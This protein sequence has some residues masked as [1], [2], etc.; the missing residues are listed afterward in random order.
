MRTTVAIC[1]W[2]R[3]DLLDKTLERMQDLC[4]PEGLEWEL[5]VVNN[6]CTDHTDDVIER[7]REALPLR[8]LIE[9]RQGLSH[10]RNCAVEAARGDLLIWTDDDVLVDPQWLAE[11]VRA[12]GE[13]PDALFFG[14]TVTPWFGT[15]PPDWVPANLD[16]LRS[17]FAIADYGACERWLEANE[18]PVGANM[19]FRTDILRRH[20]FDGSL[21]HVG[22]DVRG[23][24][25]LDLIGQINR[26]G[27]R[28]VWLPDARV[29]HWIDPDRLTYRY[30]WKWHVG[31]GR[32]IGKRV[33]ARNVATVFG[34]PRW[35]LRKYVVSRCRSLVCRLF[36]SRAYL[37]ALIDAAKSAG[38][39][40]GVRECRAQTE[41]EPP[42]PQ[43]SSPVTK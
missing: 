16:L 29:Q 18:I 12:A 34:V 15:E 39:M 2:N 10:A 35:A 22:G 20:A 42:R 11:Y 36:S 14:G 30:I 25:E 6:N 24:E 43:I 23:G 9:P 8:R 5:L 31:A 28:G 13:W 21:G 1:T 32:S 40:I 3:A 17:A 27:G 38:V 41:A 7:H 26:D 4:V 33:L 19:A 37:V